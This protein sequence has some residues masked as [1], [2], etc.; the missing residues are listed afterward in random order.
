MTTLIKLKPSL[1]RL[2]LMQ[3]VIGRFGTHFRLNRGNRPCFSSSQDRMIQR[4]SIST[5][6]CIRTYVARLDIEG[7]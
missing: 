2:S 7:V 6:T 5:L 3:G 4:A 1:T